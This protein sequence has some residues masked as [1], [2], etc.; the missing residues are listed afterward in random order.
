[1]EITYCF[2]KFIDMRKMYF[3][4]LVLCLAFA[5]K[6]QAQLY[7]Q[8]FNG[9]TIPADWSTLITNDPGTDPAVT[10]ATTSLYPSGLVPTEGTHLVRF[11]SYNVSTEGS[12]RLFM[13]TGFS[14]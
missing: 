12:I 8:G 1:M 3:F 10:F 11:N 4:G 14:I 6:T 9:G 5:I 13:T 2:T 7:T